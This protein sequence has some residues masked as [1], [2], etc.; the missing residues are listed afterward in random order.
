MER[1]PLWSVADGLAEL[2]R[3]KIELVGFLQIHP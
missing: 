2:L 3:G 1:A